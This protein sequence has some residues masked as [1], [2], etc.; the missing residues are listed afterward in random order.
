MFKIVECPAPVYLVDF[1]QTYTLIV[2]QRVPSCYMICRLV[3]MT[4]LTANFPNTTVIVIM[5]VAEAKLKCRQNYGRSGGRLR[6]PA[7]PGGKA[8]PKLRGDS[9]LEHHLCLSWMYFI[10]EK[11][12]FFCLTA[13]T[14][15]VIQK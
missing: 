4:S 13:A 12:S 11:K 5:P 7:G 15:L 1:S 8:P 9:V 14:R 6:P 3:N 10:S 2:G